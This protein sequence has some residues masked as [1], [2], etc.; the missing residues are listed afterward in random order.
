LTAHGI[1]TPLLCVITAIPRSMLT[2]VNSGAMVFYP[3]FVFR[4]VT[5]SIVRL[6]SVTT[7]SHTGYVLIM[8]ELI[9]HQRCSYRGQPSSFPFKVLVVRVCLLNFLY[10]I[11]TTCMYSISV[12]ATVAQVL[13]DFILGGQHPSHFYT[14]LG[15]LLFRVA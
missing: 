7:P 2:I 14:G 10:T 4:N 5:Y 8:L 6:Y 15:P 9:I 1:L 3:E 13:S 11:A 12:N